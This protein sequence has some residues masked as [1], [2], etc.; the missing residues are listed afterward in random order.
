MNVVVL[1]NV[2]RGRP[3]DFRRYEQQ[4]AAV[5]ARHGGSVERTVP[6][7]RPSSTDTY[8]E[9]RIVR[10]PNDDAFRAFSKDPQLSELD[11]L[12]DKVVAQMDIFAGE[13]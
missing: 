11:T 7:R 4:V 2:R 13:A 10:F 1:L 5:V 6:L 9:V 12:R 3:A 8:N